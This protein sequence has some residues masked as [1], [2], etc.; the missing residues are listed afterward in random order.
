MKVLTSILTKGWVTTYV[1][2]IFEEFGEMSELDQRFYVF[3]DHRVA[4]SRHQYN[5]Y[6]KDNGNLVIAERHLVWTFRGDKFFIKSE[7]SVV[8]ATVF[9]SG[10]IVG[11]ATRAAEIVAN[12]LGGHTKSRS[13]TRAELKALLTGGLSK[14]EKEYEK[15]EIKREIHRWGLYASALPYITT[16]VDA[17]MKLINEPEY[18][19]LKDLLQ[20]AIILKRVV[21]HTW[22]ARKVHDMH[23]R[24]TREIADIAC[25]NVPD[26]PIW[27][28]EYIPSLPE[29]VT[30][31]N[32]ERDA[33]QEGSKMHHCLGTNYRGRIARKNYIAFHVSDPEGDYTVGINLGEKCEL[34]Q[35]RRVCNNSCSEEQLNVAKALVDFAQDMYDAYVKSKDFNTVSDYDLQRTYMPF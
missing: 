22:S 8:Q 34:E 23:M 1:D 17:I 13:V 3:A 5:V 15:A 32:S 4:P 10:K 21:K 16:N 18:H 19:E 27:S 24:W 33:V 20:Q 12:L 25:R 28:L 35:S 30:L 14:Y 29:F 11:N 2:P 9:P 31:I 7:G 6:Y 26:T